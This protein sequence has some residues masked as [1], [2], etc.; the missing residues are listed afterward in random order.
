[1]TS[2]IFVFWQVELMHLFSAMAT[3]DMQHSTQ[4]NQMKASCF[5]SAVTPM[6]LQRD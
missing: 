2:H 5:T 6:G 1:M 3:T 4:N